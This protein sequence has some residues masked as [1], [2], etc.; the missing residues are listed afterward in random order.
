MLVAQMDVP[1]VKRVPRAVD[2][3][4]A[5]GALAIGLYY[6]APANSVVQTV[7]YSAVGAYGIVALLVGTCRNLR[8]AA[9]RPWYLFAAGLIAFVV[10]DSIF[11]AYAI[12]SG[13]VP[14]PSAADWIYLAAYPI[15][16]AAIALV[17]ARSGARRIRGAVIDAGIVTVKSCAL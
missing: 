9:R 16:F 5:V 12:G 7:A 3:Y 15:L 8:G 4:L 2:A 17:V 6:L 13:T 10:G 14:F 11:D 1:G